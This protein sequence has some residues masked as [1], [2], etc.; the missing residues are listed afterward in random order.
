[1]N[2]ELKV[3]L[4]KGS[5]TEPTSMENL[6]EEALAVPE[7]RRGQLCEG[8]ILDIRDDGLVV[9]IGAKRDGLV[10]KADME[11]LE[12]KF[13]VGQKIPVIVTNTRGADGNIELSVAQAKMQED[14]LTAEQI[15]NDESVYETKVLEANKG[16]LTVQFGRL[17]GF[18]PISQL[19]GFAKIRQ[20]SER[21]RRLHAMVGQS[22]MLK[23]IEVNRRR[24]RLILSQQAAEKEWRSARRKLLLEELEPGQVRTGRVS[25]ITDFGIFVNLGGLD[26]LVHISELSWGH[27]DKPAE[28]FRVGQKVQVK[29]L[30]VNRDRRRI[31]LSIKALTPDPWESVPERYR[32]GQ[33]VQGRVSQLSDFGAFVELE[34]GVEGLLHNTE[35]LSPEQKE[36]LTPGAKVLVKVIRVEPDRRRIGLSVKQVRREEWEDWESRASAM[37][38]LVE[39]VVPE[40]DDTDDD[41]LDTELD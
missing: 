9:D 18:V 19:I 34:A 37:P 33:L 17:R 27:I 41:D 35:L 36:E 25:Q 20:A 10:P 8:I 26:G 4:E 14:W 13:E 3:E 40:I 31:A 39:E 11:N 1:M 12:E 24:E 6:M 7:T 5:P 22:I 29:V 2:E 16:G 32:E 23:V 38:K 30:S 21:S 28:A 15:K